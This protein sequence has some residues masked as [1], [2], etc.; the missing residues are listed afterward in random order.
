MLG[1][2]ASHP[3]TPELCFLA[4]WGM[5]TM[6][7]NMPMEAH[8]QENRGINTEYGA[9][10]KWFPLTGMAVSYDR[11]VGVMSTG[12]YKLNIKTQFNLLF[13]KFL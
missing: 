7:E 1:Y 6:T 12:I 4:K 3:P 13:L 8:C 11:S 9:L 5:A 2:S 10:V